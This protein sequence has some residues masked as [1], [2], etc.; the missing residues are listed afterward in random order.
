[1]GLDIVSWLGMALRWFHV[2]AGIAWIGSSFYFMWLDNALSPPANPKDKEDGVKGELWA[3]HSGG[4]YYKKK[5]MVAPAHMPQDLHWFKWEAYFT[6]LSGFMLL[7]L[8]YYYGADMYLIDRAKADLT[9][10]QA[11]LIGLGAITVGWFFYDG[12]CRTKLGENNALFGIVWFAALTAAGYYLTKIFTGRGA[13]IHIGAIIGTVM[14]ANVFAIIIPN[15]KKVVASLLAGEKPDPALGLK[16]K[17][18]SLHN[19]YMTLPVIL[20]M[21]SNHYPMLIGNPYNWAV[22]AG[23]SVSAWFI[24]HFFN[25]KHTGVVNYVYPAVGVVIYVAVMLAAFVMQPGPKMPLSSTEVTDVSD[26]EVFRIVRS[27]CSSC[28]SSAPTNEGFPA[29]PQGVMFDSMDQIRTQAARIR[30]QAVDS[31]TMPLG[32][33]TGMTEEERQTLGAWISAQLPR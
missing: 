24:R 1:M 23:L 18:R 6:W 15:Q 5:Y 25:L 28:H 8:I 30:A 13:F 21:I 12:L 9:Q 3:V 33:A 22:L 26:A 31:E 7:A 20:I 14:A 29:A 2:I 17:Q 27:H 4:F 32:N 19:N 16:A 10:M 11:V